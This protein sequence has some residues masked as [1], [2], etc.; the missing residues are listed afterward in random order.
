MRRLLWTSS[1]VRPRRSR[2]SRRLAPMSNICGGSSDLWTTAWSCGKQD[3]GN[4]LSGR[5]GGGR[6]KAPERGLL[7]GI[8]GTD[9]EPESATQ[10]IRATADGDNVALRF[11][12]LTAWGLAAAAA[13]SLLLGSAVH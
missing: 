13:A 7:N 11:N 10:A 8:C 9:P 6:G 12:R 1:A 4:C 2:A 5:R 3:H